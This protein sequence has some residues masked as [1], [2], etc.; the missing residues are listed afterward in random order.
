M[1][2]REREKGKRD[3]GKRNDQDAGRPRRAAWRQLQAGIKSFLVGINDNDDNEAACHRRLG[4]A[5]IVQRWLS[6]A[7]LGIFS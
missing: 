3:S 5:I 1:Q 4:P 2:E 7:V 6:L